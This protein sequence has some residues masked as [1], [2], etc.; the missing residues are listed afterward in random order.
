MSKSGVS[1][2][3]GAQRAAEGMKHGGK[4]LGG[5]TPTN[6]FKGK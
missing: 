2:N 6:P 1:G 4:K 3:I 5:K